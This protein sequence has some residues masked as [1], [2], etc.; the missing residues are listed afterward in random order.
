MNIREQLSTIWTREYI[1]QL[2]SFIKE[3]GFVYSINDTEKDILITGINPS[4]IDNDDLNSFGFD[5][6]VTL[7]EKKW[8]NYWGPIKKI[9]IDDE[10]N[11]DLSNRSA[12]LDIFILEKKSR[13]N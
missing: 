9:V 13:K 6:Q 7:K 10:K 12:Y 4:F 11:I 2:P 3:R 8:N 5:F 1:N